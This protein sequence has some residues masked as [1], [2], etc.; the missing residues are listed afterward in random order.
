LAQYRY[1]SCQQDLVEEFFGEKCQTRCV[2]TNYEIKLISGVGS[3]S[4]LGKTEC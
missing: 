4:L 2:D 3:C 1:T